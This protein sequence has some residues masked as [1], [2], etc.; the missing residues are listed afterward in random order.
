MKFTIKRVQL[1]VQTISEKLEREILLTLLFKP[2][3]VT[4]RVMIK[5]TLLAFLVLLSQPPKAN[6]QLKQNPSKQTLSSMKSIAAH[7][8]PYLL[9][10]ISSEMK[11]KSG[12]YHKPELISRVPDLVNQEQKLPSHASETAYGT[13]QG[14]KYLQLALSQVLLQCFTLLSLHNNQMYCK[15]IFCGLRETC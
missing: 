4:V 13:L 6:T 12:T 5:I 7:L 10:L 3:T 11:K 2:T 1:A 9:M 15:K 14:N 8:Q